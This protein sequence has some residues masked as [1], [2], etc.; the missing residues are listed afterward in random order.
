MLMPSMVMAA[1]NKLATLWNPSLGSVSKLIVNVE[2]DQ[3]FI[4]GLF[5][6]GYKLYIKGNENL[7]GANIPASMVNWALANPLSISAT[8]IY[9]TNVNNPRGDIIPVAN[10]PTKIYLTI[11]PNTISGT[12]IIVCP[13]SNYSTTTKSFD[14]CTRG[15]DFSGSSE[16]SITSYKKTHSAGSKVIISNPGQFYNNFIDIDS[17]QTK[18][19]VLTFTSSPII[20]TP[21]SATQAANKSYVDGVAMS[22]GANASTTIKGISYLSSNPLVATSPIALNSEEV[23]TTTGANKVVR[24]NGSGKINTD[25]IDQTASYTWSGTSTFTGTTQFNGVTTVNGGPIDDTVHNL[26]AGENITAG[27]AVAIA[28]TTCATTTNPS[29]ATQDNTFNSGVTTNWFG[30]TITIPAGLSLINKITWYLSFGSSRTYTLHIRN[31]SAGLPTGADLATGTFTGL[32]A[33]SEVSIILS[34][35]LTVTSTNQ[36]ALLF[37]IDTTNTSINY[38]TADTYSGGARIASSDSGATWAT[39]T[40]DMYFKVDTFYTAGYAIKTDASLNNC[41]ANNFIGFAT[42]TKNAGESTAIK[43]FGLNNN[44]TSLSPGFTYYLSDTTPGGISTAAGAQ[45]RKIG[46][47]ISATEILIKHDNQ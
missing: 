46:A 30:Q 25:F 42:Q 4:Q 9:L 10:M 36:Y 18:A 1:N 31:V 39:S 2:K 17:D 29:Q 28:S 43:I 5:A 8:K 32:S 38:S 12:E 45:S 41:R 23:A 37:S 13:S 40:G 6:V 3:N 19:G 33:G 20:P 15:L 35:P 16:A 11:E 7:L 47:A 26:F 14:N 21:S 22:G 44:Q 27:N 34:T 24:T